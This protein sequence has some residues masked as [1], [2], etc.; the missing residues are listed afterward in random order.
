MR[1]RC[2]HGAAALVARLGLV[3]GSGMDSPAEEGMTLAG[4]VRKSRAAL[5]LAALLVAMPFGCESRVKLGHFEDDKVAALE[6]LDV[7]HQRF[8]AEDFDAIYE[9][10]ADGLRARPKTEVVANMRESRRTWGKF[11]SAEVKSAACFPNEV[12]LVVHARF[13]KGQAGEMV[14]WQVPNKARLLSFVIFPGSVQ[15]PAGTENECRSRR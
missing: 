8:S 11:I 12:R 15:V 10:A 9:N 5:P 13:E 3:Q 7:L 6:A 14:V 4:A 2:G 1:G